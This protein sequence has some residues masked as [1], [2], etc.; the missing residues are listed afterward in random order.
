[1]APEIHLYTEFHVSSDFMM[2]VM[3]EVSCLKE[4]WIPHSF[5]PSPLP[6]Q[7]MPF[8]FSYPA[9]HQQKV[10]SLSAISK[11]ISKSGQLRL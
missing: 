6:S 5:L 11:P 8:S 2:S 4:Q 9:V 7:P 10:P 1:M 3:S